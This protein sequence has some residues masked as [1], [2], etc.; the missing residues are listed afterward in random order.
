MEDPGGLLCKYGDIFDIDNGNLIK[1]ETC[2]ESD[3]T[4]YN[5]SV[6]EE[7]PLTDPEYDEVLSQ[8]VC[9]SDIITY[10]SQKLFLAYLRSSLTAEMFDHIVSE[11]NIKK[12]LVGKTM[13]EE[14][15]EYVMSVPANKIG[16]TRNPTTTTQYTERPQPKPAPKFAPQPAPEIAPEDEEDDLQYDDD[17]EP[18]PDRVEAEE[19][20]EI[21]AIKNTIEAM[22]KQGYK[23][24]AIPK[25]F[26]EMA[27][28]TPNLD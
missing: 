28:I 15:W 21:V 27:G 26:F 9:F 23:D 3:K 19:P 25:Q 17:A 8:V 20:P 5:P 24:S 11:T 18:N 14:E 4:T 22:R 7:Y 6:D 16:Y 2:G 12:L 1:L 10:A 13:T